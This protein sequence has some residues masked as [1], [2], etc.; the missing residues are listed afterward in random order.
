MK[1]LLR[2]FTASAALMGLLIAVA[3][4]HA[5][6]DRLVIST[7]ST[8]PDRVSG[9]D[10]LARVSVPAA[11][12]LA[13]V[14]VTLNGEDVT[15]LF[16]PEGSS[17][18][19]VGLVTGLRDGQNE[20]AASVRSQGRGSFARLHVTN[21][22]IH[23]PIFA[24]PHQRPWVCETATSGLGDPPAS[25]PCVAPTRHDWFYRTTGGT[26]QPLPAG[27][28]PADLAQTTTIDGHTVNYIVR[29]ESGAIN[30]SIY[31]IAILDDPASP[32]ANPWSS[33]GQKP[34]PGW[35]GK[36]TYPFGGGCG[37]GYRSGSNAVTSALQ[38]DPLSLGFAVA[39]GTRN[40]LG[41]GCNDVISAETVMM[42][43]ERFIEQYGIPKFTIGSGGSGGAIQQHL[44]AHNYPGLLDAL[45]PGISY[46]EVT[47]ILPDVVDC[48][49]L[50]RY[51]DTVANPADW[52][53][54]R[55]AA[56]DG[57]AVATSG[58]NTGRTVCQ[59]GWAG[60]SDGLMNPSTRFNAVVPVD[61]RYDAVTNPTGVRATFWDGLV[62]VFGIDPDTGFARS[63]Y[64]NVGIQYGFNALNAGAITTTEF[65][66]LNE[67]IGG[68]DADG[69]PVPER[70]RADLRA[71]E[72]AYRT[73]RV[74]M[75]G[76]NFTL[77]II[78]TRTYTDLVA[79]IHTRI[80][81]FSFLERLQRANGTTANQVNWL[82][83]G[84]GNPSLARMALLAHN[85]WLENI[86]A[87]TSGAP[88]AEKVIANK[89]ATVKDACWFNGTMHEEPHTLDPAATC[90]TL[91]PVF[92]TVRIAAGGPIAADILKCK[93]K[94]VDLADYQ[95]T[96][97][98]EEQARLKK[99]FPTGVC[100]WSVP[101]LKQLPLAGT[102]LDFT[103]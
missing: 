58:A 73:G 80:R 96:F 29:V 71:I 60:F 36:L 44:I 99:I 70:S 32:V 102:W 51:F 42:I 69:N 65:L 22:P 95:V 3:P 61:V 79:D 24:G 75:S 72:I 84:T 82:I 56:V 57:Y 41:T 91:M 5:G 34:G 33:G 27:P 68:L 103:P 76:E 38:N 18:A 92:S 93:L 35:N 49:I 62:N 2:A 74:V 94:K 17:H 47:S 21:F 6:P 37:P 31:R 10:V 66:D 16:M 48:E 46:P 50:N 100:D 45:T 19:L 14:R 23:G 83:G 81:T 52:P 98:P 25:G 64:D 13:D 30:E 88:D 97:T 26:F 8:G 4:A 12:A 86:L 90:N 40:T 101:G 43:K 63:A 39:F 87:D 89:P 77:P 54:P 9:G 20:I 59:I 11:F 78:D 55:R 7:L 1:R 53:G 67:K 15:S 85:E 28:L